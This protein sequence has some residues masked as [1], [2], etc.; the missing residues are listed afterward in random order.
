MVVYVYY[1]ENRGR[2]QIFLFLRVKGALCF[3]R[4]E[5]FCIPSI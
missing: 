2:G 4:T 5:C 1:Q 3:R